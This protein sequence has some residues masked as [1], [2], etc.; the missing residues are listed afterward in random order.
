MLIHHGQVGSLW[1]SQLVAAVG[2][3]EWSTLDS[4]QK[5]DR[6]LDRCE[7]VYFKLLDNKIGLLTTRLAPQY[8]QV[9]MVGAT[10]GN[11]QLTV[12]E[13]RRPMNEAMMT[14]IGSEISCSIDWSKK[15]GEKAGANWSCTI[16]N[17]T[18]LLA[19][20]LLTVSVGI[21]EIQDSLAQL[22]QR[23]QWGACVV[24]IDN[25][26]VVD[27]SHLTKICQLLHTVLKLD[28]YAEQRLGPGAKGWVG[29]DRFHVMHSMTPLSNNQDPRWYPLFILDVRNRIVVRDAVAE[30]NVDRKLKDGLIQKKVTIAGVVFQIKVG[31]KHSPEQIIEMKASGVYHAM[32]STHPYCIVPEYLISRDSIDSAMLQWEETVKVDAFTANGTIPFP[33]PTRGTTIIASLEVLQRIRK[34]SSLR[35]KNCVPPDHLRPYAWRKTGDTFLGMD[36]MRPR[37]H[38]CNNEMWN[39]TM[40]DF[41][42]GDNTTVRTPA[43]APPS[44]PIALPL[45]DTCAF[46]V[47]D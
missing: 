28:H 26:P 6:I 12:L 23:P 7:F 32:F 3:D 40:P 37:F 13:G 10:I 4:D 19:L 5:R 39:S 15:P 45:V 27:E 44:S 24:I 9:A 46:L 42:V 47:P 31:Q 38:S 17:D 25:V 11:Y 22:T 33:H 29:Q 34:N 21:G 1:W 18:G 35:F 14:S 30:E 2:D 36:V 20:E 8:N 41:V 43:H 16:T